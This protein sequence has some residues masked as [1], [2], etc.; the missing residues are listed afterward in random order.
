MK[1]ILIFIILTIFPAFLFGDCRD[2]LMDG[3]FNKEE[4]KKIVLYSEKYYDFI[5]VSNFKTHD[6]AIDVGLESGS[7]V[8]G[9]P[10]VSGS[11]FTEA[12]R[13]SWKKEYKQQR[14]G[15]HMYYSD[16]DI[17]KGGILLKRNS[18][19]IK[20]RIKGGNN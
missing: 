19:T 6:E 17:M 2:V 9:I 4:V 16:Q 3:V 14:S 13:I 10:L 7:I 11:T 8:Y 12:Q 5:Y 20:R 15:Q 18:I 1:R